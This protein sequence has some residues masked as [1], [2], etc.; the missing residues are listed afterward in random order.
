MMRTLK[1]AILGLLM[2]SPMT[3]YDIYKAFGSGLG[4]F[5]SAKHSQ[6][7]PELKR[8]TEESLVR[9]TTVIQGEKMEKKVYEITKQGKEDFLQWLSL[10]PPLEPTAKDVFRL[11]SYYSQWLPEET[12]LEL[13]HQ[14]MIKHTNKLNFLI[15]Q[16][17]DVYSNVDPVS[18]TGEARG[19]YLVL[20]G[21]IM[22]ENAYLD[23]LKQSQELV[24]AWK[25]QP[26]SPSPT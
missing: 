12:Y 7:Y 13:I 10:D 20:T 25:D 11:R 16:Q 18:L 26:T 22:R 9:F 8:L 15:K 2:Q 6:I 1:Y 24:T 17:K 23:W 19:D 3:G 21:A 5:W 14:Q 4:S